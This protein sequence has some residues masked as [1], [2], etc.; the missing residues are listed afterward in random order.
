[1]LKIVDIMNEEFILLFKKYQKTTKFF[2]NELML[3]IVCYYIG[4]NSK[5]IVC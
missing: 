5:M 4:F 1:M 2:D 3:R